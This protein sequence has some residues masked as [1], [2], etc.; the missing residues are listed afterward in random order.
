MLTSFEKDRKT[1]K[2]KTFICRRRRHRENKSSSDMEILEKLPATT[3]ARA[4][5]PFFFSKYFSNMYCIM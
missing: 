2:T 3:F 4:F 1:E 5:R